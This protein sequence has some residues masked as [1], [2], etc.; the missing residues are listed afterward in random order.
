MCLKTVKH[1][2]TLLYN[3]SAAERAL[4]W[5]HGGRLHGGRPHGGRLHGGRLYGGRLHGGRLHSPCMEE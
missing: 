3:Y 1:I 5:R 4:T 2:I